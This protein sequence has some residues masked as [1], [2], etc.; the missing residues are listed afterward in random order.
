MQVCQAG[1]EF[2]SVPGEMALERPVLARLEILDFDFA[3]DDHAQGGAL[4]ATGGKPA[5]DLF[6]QQGREIESDEVVQ[7]A[8]EPVSPGGDAPPFLCLRDGPGLRFK[9]S[10]DSV[11]EPVVKIGI[12]IAVID[13]GEAVAPI[14]DFFD[15]PA[16]RCNT[17]C[18]LG[19]TVVLGRPFSVTHP[20]GI[21][22][23]R[24]IVI[25]AVIALKV[26]PEKS[27]RRAAGG[28]GR[29]DVHRL[30]PGQRG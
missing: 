12:D 14:N 11:G 5:T 16:T 29:R 4:H 15:R 19:G 1:G 30:V 10:V 18:R 25:D 27:G 23:D 7:R 26:Q 24:R 2:L 20:I 28:R 6:P 3:L 8:A 21:Q 22:A 13:G 9:V 17:P